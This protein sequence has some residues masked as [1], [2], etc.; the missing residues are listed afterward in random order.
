[1]QIRPTSL[2]NTQ[3]V[4]LNTQRADTCCNTTNQA[5]VDQL[6]L[7][8]EAQM[9]SGGEIRTDLVAQIKTDIANGVYE[10]DAKLDAAVERLLDE[11]G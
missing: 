1:M 11:V 6:D 3:S 7:S 4:N 10:T 2:Q 5:P 9:L 8:A